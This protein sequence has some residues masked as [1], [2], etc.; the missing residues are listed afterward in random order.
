MICRSKLLWS[1]KLPSGYV[2]I[3]LEN[4]PFFRWFTY[5]VESIYHFYIF[6]NIH[7]YLYLYVY[8]CIY[9][10]IYKICTYLRAM[11]CVSMTCR[12][13]LPWVARWFPRRSPRSSPPTRTISPRWTSRSMKAALAAL[14]GERWAKCPC[15]PVGYVNIA[16]END[17][18]H[19]WVFPLEKCVFA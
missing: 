15:L 14:A 10:Y 2:K 1:W 19:K 18:R 3:V 17:H 9:I 16:I 12:T 7:Q 8:M 6:L 11:Y 4:G 5:C 13:R